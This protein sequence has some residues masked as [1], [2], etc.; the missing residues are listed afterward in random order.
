MERTP[1]L[2]CAAIT[3]YDPLRHWGA[4]KS[5]TKMTIGV[6][7]V[8][9][10]GTMGIKLAKAMGHRVVAI[11]SNSDKEKMSL[12]KGADLFLCSSN[13]MKHMSG[14]MDLILNTIP[15][16]HDCMIYIDLLS[17]NGTLV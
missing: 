11:S 5:D 14:Q 9:G 4:T 3:M 6:I 17:T 15:S 10:L 12:E 16:K 8:G 13:D 2:M 1:P 7:G